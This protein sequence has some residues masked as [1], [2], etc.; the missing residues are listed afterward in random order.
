MSDYIKIDPPMDVTDGDCYLA[1]VPISELMPTGPLIRPIL[2]NVIRALG[3]NYAVPLDRMGELVQGYLDASPDMRKLINASG[4]IYKPLEAPLLPRKAVSLTDKAAQALSYMRAAGRPVTGQELAAVL[5]A[6][7]TAN[8]I[9]REGAGSSAA[10]D[11]RKAGYTV[12]GKWDKVAGDD[13]KL[14]SVYTYNLLEGPS[15]E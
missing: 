3:K 10:R 9:V 1:C 8:G 6:E 2:G 13:G 11:M 15:H 7:D 14:C 4:L 5:Y 12:V